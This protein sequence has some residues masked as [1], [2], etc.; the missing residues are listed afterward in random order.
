MKN[1]NYYAPT[2]IV[3]G[4]GRIKEVGEIVKK[5]GKKIW[6]ESAAGNGE[7]GFSDL[8]YFQKSEEI[9]AGVWN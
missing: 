4:C 7:H 2:E 5:Y 3:F 8:G 1:F 9:S 6:K